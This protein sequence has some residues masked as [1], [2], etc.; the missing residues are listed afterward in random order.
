M[1]FL[2]FLLLISPS[3]SPPSPLCFQDTFHLPFKNLS[4][5]H[6]CQPPSG[7]YFTAKTGSGS[8]ATLEV[9]C[10]PRG[11][12]FP[13]LLPSCLLLPSPICFCSS[14]LCN[15][16]EVPIPNIPSPT[17]GPLQISSL[18]LLGSFI[19][20][21]V[22]LGSF[23]LVLVRH[24]RC[25]SYRVDVEPAILPPTAM[26]RII[27]H[28]EVIRREENSFTILSLV[29]AGMGSPATCARVVGR[30]VD[31]GKV[32]IHSPKMGLPG[33]GSS[34]AKYSVV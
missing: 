17:M 13:V 30:L 14:P 8:I 3:L 21:L 7:I 33:G 22:L 1:K 26:D 25:K 2:L 10:W 34:P 16:G 6:T 19:L 20:V 11:E 28:L 23:I 24:R 15:V 9:G 29:G 18:V 5:N 4:T 31:A 12:N 32:R 27:S